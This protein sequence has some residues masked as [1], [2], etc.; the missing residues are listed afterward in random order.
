M[1]FKPRRIVLDSWAVM[2]YFKDEPSGIKVEEIIAHA[3]DARTPLLMTTVNAGEIFYIFKRQGSEAE[4][5]QA[6]SD[7]LTLGI[8][9]VSA[10]WKLSRE[11]ALL[12]AAHPISFADCFSAALAKVE[13]AFLVTGD[14]EFKLLEKEIKIIWV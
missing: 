6:I 5:N 2:A 13:N 11:A 10:D 7:L 14:E 1:A 3:Q 8:E 12:K 4:A 9:F